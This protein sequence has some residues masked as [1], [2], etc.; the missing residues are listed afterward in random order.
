MAKKTSSIIKDLAK[1]IFTKGSQTQEQKMGAIPEIKEN[2]TYNFRRPKKGEVK[3]NKIEGL[4][5]KR[6]QRRVKELVWKIKKAPYKMREIDKLKLQKERQ[7]ALKRMFKETSGYQ[8]KFGRKGIE[9]HISE[10]Q[11]EKGLKYFEKERM[12]EIKLKG[13]H[14]ERKQAQRDAQLTHDVLGHEA[15]PKKSTGIFSSIFKKAS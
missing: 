14:K 1:G 13:T 10:K 2:K 11:L 7:E 3:E 4:F 5:G 6:K 15:K 12:P 9:G 8:E